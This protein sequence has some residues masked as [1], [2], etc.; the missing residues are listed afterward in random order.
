MY[1]ATSVLHSYLPARGIPQGGEMLSGACDFAPPM[2]RV[3]DH[4]GLSEPS[5]R[6][7]EGRCCRR[8]QTQQLVAGSDP[9]PESGGL[10]RGVALALLVALV[11]HQLLRLTRCLAV[12]LT[13]GQR[14]QMHRVFACGTDPKHCMPPHLS[15][16]L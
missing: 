1:L 4:F 3:W 5:C 6:A 13:P 9:P 12:A 8:V 7:R 15:H 11:R 16:I 2:P 14:G 10:P